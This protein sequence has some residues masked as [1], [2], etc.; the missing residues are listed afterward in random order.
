MH[1]ILLSDMTVLPFHAL[2]S[3]LLFHLRILFA[4][5][6]CRVFLVVVK[7]KQVFSYDMELTFIE[8]WH[9]ILAE[10]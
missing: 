1:G 2:G 9:E 7:M 8:V 10:K 4:C 5:V 6:F 3:Y